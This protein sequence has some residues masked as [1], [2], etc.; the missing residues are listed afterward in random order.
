[1][2]KADGLAGGK[3][4]IVTANKEEALIAARSM[5]VDGA[6]GDAGKTIIIEDLLPGVEMSVHAICDGERYFVLP[7][8]RD[9]KRVGDGDEGPNTGG[10]GAYAPVAVDA[11]LME[12]IERQVLKPTL[13]GMRADGSPYRGVLYAGL[14]VSQ[15]G[16]PYLLEHNVRFGDPETQ[17]LM[18]LLD[19][20]VGALLLSAARGQLDDTAITV[21]ERHAVVVVLA[22]EG[23]PR[24]PR[25]GR[26]DRRARRRGAHR[27]RDAV[28]RRHQ[29]TGRQ[30][31]HR[32]RARA[33]RDGGG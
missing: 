24:S 18:S 4:A 2:V 19:G 31:H 15:D 9:H 17:V 29:K 13:D 8:S 26:R 16:T 25:K 5:L 20:D 3:G 27:R 12:R 21:A 10:M 32:R 28:S 6:F 14:M 1:M 23:Y 30:L 7:V 22:S 33:R 11:A